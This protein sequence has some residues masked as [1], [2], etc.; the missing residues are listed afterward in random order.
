MS[1][2]LIPAMAQQHNGRRISP[3]EFKARSIC[4]LKDKACLTQEEANALFPVFEEFK[5]KQRDINRQKNHLKRSCP[6]TEEEAQKTVLKI[7]QLDKE[8]AE[9]ESTYYK[10][11]C[12]T[13]PAQKV[14][15]VLLAEDQFH[16]D[17]LMKFN[18]PKGEK[19]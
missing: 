13:I 2:V 3:E 1:L 15:K 18:K 14:F 16:R 4:Y 19:K 11:M 8:S 7:A 6:A 12:K 9:L 17:M 5:N 10:K